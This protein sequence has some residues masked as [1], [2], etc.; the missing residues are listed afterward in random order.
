MDDQKETAEAHTRHGRF[1]P[2]CV[3]LGLGMFA[4]S[5]Q[6][7]SDALKLAL[8]GP[9]LLLFIGGILSMRGSSHTKENI[10]QVNDVKS[11][12]RKK[13]A[14]RRCP[15]PSIMSESFGRGDLAFHGFAG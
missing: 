2:I 7:H 1:A 10:E 6:V 8:S 11:P 9:G 12:K 13:F 15:N 3:G 14:M 4:G 5:H